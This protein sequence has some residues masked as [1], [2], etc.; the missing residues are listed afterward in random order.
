MEKAYEIVR[1]ILEIA[2]LGVYI[3]N[4]KGRIDYLNSTMLVISGDTYQQFNTLNVFKAPL[5][6]R[7]YGCARG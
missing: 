6:I 3:V 7:H 1:S 2:P 5:S 4:K